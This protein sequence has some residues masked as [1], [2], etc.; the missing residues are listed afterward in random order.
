M[1]ASL[2]KIHSFVAY[3]INLAMFLRDAPRPA[4]CEQI[5]ERL[6]L[7]RALKWVAH[8]RF[9][10]IQHSDC[11]APVGFDPMSQVLAELGMEHGSPLTLRFHRASLAAVQL[12]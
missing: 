9:N 5:S 12:R 1:V 6:G 8:H 4:T 7:A 3:T 11:G 10:Q 2:K